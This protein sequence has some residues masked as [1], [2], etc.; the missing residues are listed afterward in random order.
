M[1]IKGIRKLGE[2]GQFFYAII[3]HWRMSV[4]CSFLAVSIDY[5]DFD[6][7]QL[8]LVSNWMPIFSYLIFPCSFPILQLVGTSRIPSMNALYW[9][10]VSDWSISH[11][12]AESKL[13]MTKHWS[14]VGPGLQIAFATE[15]ARKYCQRISDGIWNDVKKT[16][17]PLLI[18]GLDSQRSSYWPW[19]N[20]LR[21]F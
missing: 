13:Q 14:C 9:K 7:L 11:T 1:N 12:K 19:A 4:F 8:Y 20:S 21:E 6:S 16:Y 18:S 3:L 17:T 2:S 10:A 15:S 5:L